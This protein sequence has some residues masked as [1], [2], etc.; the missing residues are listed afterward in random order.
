MLLG[1]GKGGALGRRKARAARR[2]LLLINCLYTFVKEPRGQHFS[3]SS[4]IEILLINR[5]SNH[6]PADVSHCPSGVGHVY[7]FCVSPMMKRNRASTSKEV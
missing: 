6:N 2:S 3:Y 1:E 7:I 5:H 4:A